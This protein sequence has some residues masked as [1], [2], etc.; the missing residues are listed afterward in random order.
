VDIFPWQGLHDAR[1]IIDVMDKTCK[2]ILEEK[3]QALAAGDEALSGKIGQGKDIMS[4][5]SE[6]RH[7][8]THA[9]P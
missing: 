5:L 8:L 3:K 7:N 9:Q 4:I 1:D 6:L 2:E